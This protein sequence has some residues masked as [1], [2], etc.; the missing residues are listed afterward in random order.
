MKSYKRLR[1]KSNLK[2]TILYKKEN[3]KQEKIELEQEENNSFMEE[4]VD[5]NLKFNSKITND[6]SFIEKGIKEKIKDFSIE[7]KS[8]NNN[9]NKKNSYTYIDYLNDNYNKDEDE[10]YSYKKINNKINNNY[11][12]KDEDN[13]NNNKVNIKVPKIKNFEYFTQK[14]KEKLNK[15]NNND[16]YNKDNNFNSNNSNNNN[17]INSLN[18]NNKI[19]QKNLSE[20]INILTKYSEKLNTEWIPLFDENGVIYF[21]NRITNDLSFNFP[22]IFN[23]KSNKYENLL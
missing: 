16:K 2:N 23:K 8:F 1:Q 3:K 11:K 9:I 12:D 18:N 5:L 6:N 15:Y 7:E 20:K 17:E 19:K 10:N 22:K 13:N 14:E 4:K 21:H